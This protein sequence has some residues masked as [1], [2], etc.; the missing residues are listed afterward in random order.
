MAWCLPLDSLSAVFSPGTVV[1][2]DRG[3]EIEGGTELAIMC[4]PHR[5]QHN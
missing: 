1:G 4:Y 5:Q 3:T 2:V